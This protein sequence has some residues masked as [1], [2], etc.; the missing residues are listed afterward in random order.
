MCAVMVVY[1]LVLHT[2]LFHQLNLDETA[3]WIVVIVVVVTH[4]SMK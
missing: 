2:V 4:I 1:S 3:N